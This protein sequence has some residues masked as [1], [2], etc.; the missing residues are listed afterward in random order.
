L[1][2]NFKTSSKRNSLTNQNFDTDSIT[3]HVQKYINN[4]KKS[5]D[6]RLHKQICSEAIAFLC[7]PQN[8]HLLKAL[9]SNAVSYLIDKQYELTGLLSFPKFEQNTFELIVDDTISV[10]CQVPWAIKF[11]SADTILL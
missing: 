5:V 3:P 6:L 2:F 4:L 1:D 8:H 7:S 10:I 11:E 9:Y